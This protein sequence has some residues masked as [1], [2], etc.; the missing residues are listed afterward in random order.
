MSGTGDATGVIVVAGE[1]LIDL[2]ANADE[3]RAVPGGGPYNVARTIARLG[4][5]AVYLGTLS[6]DRFGVRLREALRADGVDDR[7][8]PLSEDP[9]TLAVAQ[10]GEDGGATYGF[11]VERTSAADLSEAQACTV[12]DLGPD[13]VYVGTLGLVLEPAAASYEAL[14]R[15]VGPDTLVVVDPNCRPGAIRDE[16]AYR[17]RIERVLSRAD[18]VKV[19]TEDLDYLVPDADHVAGAR[20]LLALGP[21]V[22]LM[23][24]GGRDV[25]IVAADFHHVVPVPPVPVVDTV[26]AGDSFLGAVLAHWA[27]T[28][29]HR[30]ELRDE[31]AVVR[32]VQ[33]GIGVS[34]IT[35]GRVG[36]D[37][38]RLAEL[39]ADLR[40]S[41]ASS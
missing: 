21:A 18:L 28:G 22:V 15:S 7:R 30:D 9:T 37:P 2:I 31:G 35:C 26:G 1:S 32:A 39:P 38:P 16:S 23:T 19:S 12:L 4:R 29:H 13:I 33:V 11:Y 24:D 8:A 3:L 36:A 14:V 41:L 34:G 20:R 25:H 40:R 6:T 5:P 10:I 17:A 27:A